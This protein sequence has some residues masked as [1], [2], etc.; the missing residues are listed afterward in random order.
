MSG[1]SISSLRNNEHR[2][3]LVKTSSEWYRTREEPI[4]TAFSGQQREW[5]EMKLERRVGSRSRA[6][7]FLSIS[8]V[9]VCGWTILCC[10]AVLC[11]PGCL[12]ASLASTHY[13]PAHCAPPILTTK[14]LPRHCQMSPPGSTRSPWVENNWSW[15]CEPARNVH[16]IL[17]FMEKY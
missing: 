3:P 1:R 9:D 8:T 16:F 6:T 7:G 11:T 15:V 4:Q 14:T 10:G 13:A 2:V 12:A 5:H 17:G